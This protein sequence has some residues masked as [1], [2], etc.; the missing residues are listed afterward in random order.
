VGLIVRIGAV[1]SFKELLSVKSTGPSSSNKSTMGCGCK[2]GSL[3]A[4][5]LRKPQRI[6]ALTLSTYV[7]PS[8]RNWIQSGIHFG[9]EFHVLGRNQPFEGW[10]MRTRLYLEGIQKWSRSPDDVIVLVDSNDLF[11]IDRPEVTFERFLQLQLQMV[12]GGEP[13]CCNGVSLER[14]KELEKEFYELFPK[15]RYRFPNGG[16]L[17]GY[18]DQIQELLRQN[19]N[20]IDDQAGYVEK[21]L[22]RQVMLQ[23]DVGQSFV[24]NFPNMTD[25]YWVF[26]DDRSR[27]ELSHWNLNKT[28]PF[29]VNKDN[30]VQPSVAHFSGHNY[31]DYTRVAQWI[32]GESRVKERKNDWPEFNLAIDPKLDLNTLIDYVP[33]TRSV[34]RIPSDYKMVR[35]EQ[36]PLHPMVSTRLV[37][38]ARQPHDTFMIIFYVV[39]SIILA[40]TTFVIIGIIVQRKPKLE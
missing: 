36:D 24:G 40:I 26:D 10:M 12:I 18:S 4:L 39:L 25:F 28:Y 27:D 22:N 19:L 21:I 20:A 1:L 9:W 11:F 6:F 38:S 31:K 34:L 29:I 13:A 23:V 3:A 14:K 16:F 15:E 8:F 37:G 32:F 17:I 33:K 30:S 5:Q 7:C 2:V 35:N